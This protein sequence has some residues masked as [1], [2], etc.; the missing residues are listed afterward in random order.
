MPRKRVDPSDIPAPTPIVLPRYQPFARED[1]PVDPREALT[2]LLKDNGRSTAS[3]GPLGFSALGLDLKVDVDATQL[4]PD[5]AYVPDFVRWEQLGEGAS[6]AEQADSQTSSGNSGSPGPQ[7]Y[8]E[9]RKELSNNNEDAFRTIRR[10]SPQ[11]GQQQARLG[12][13]YEFFRC[14]E[15]FTAYWEDP[16]Q[17]PSLPPSPELYADDPTPTATK[18]PTADAKKQDDLFHIVRISAGDTMPAEFRHKLIA[19]FIKM[20][21]YDFGCTV[22]QS[23]VEP[24]LQMSSPQGHFPIRKSYLASHCQFIFQSPRTREAARMGTVVGPV[25]SVSCRTTVNFST[26]DIET[27]QSLDLAR[28]IVATLVTAQQRNREGKEETRFGAGQW[29]T[30]K[31]RWGGGPGGPI[32]REVDKDDIAGDK[33]IRPADQDIHPPSSGPAPKRP[34]RNM[35]MY[36]NYRMIRPPRST[37]DKKTKF[38]AIG[39][40]HCTNYDDIF[41]VS[42]LFHHVSF[43]RVRVPQ[44][45]LEVLDG[46]PEPDPTRRSWGK[47]EAWRTPWYDLFDAKQRVEG[48]RMMWVIMAYQMRS[49]TGQDVAM[50][51]A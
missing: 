36:D 42:S 46:S 16:T 37:W 9:R 44:R 30:T 41:L 10:I 45:L 32:G 5:P 24:R 20:V 34:R 13:A 15:T 29:W 35:A 6:Q 17:P 3:L 28:E 31:K 8:L 48:M 11:P 23:Q 26:P 38:T 49:D 7:I 22:G 14:L 51:E 21:S 2:T 39:K 27:T 40:Q 50:G 1:V 19:A 33:D 4:I 25:A 12:N 43:M 18:A 47:L